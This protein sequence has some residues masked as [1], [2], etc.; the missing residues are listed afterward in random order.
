[1]KQST[2]RTCT[3][4]E[5]LREAIACFTDECELVVPVEVSYAHDGDEGFCFVDR[6]NN[7]DIDDLK[8]MI[9]R[10]VP[11]GTD[12]IAVSELIDEFFYGKG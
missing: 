3:T 12:S 1:M 5:E 11:T 4:I 8:G 6:A 2:K 9:L 10:H 7:G